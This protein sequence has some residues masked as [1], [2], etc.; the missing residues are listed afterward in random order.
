MPKRSVKDKPDPPKKSK[1]SVRSLKLPNLKVYQ[2]IIVL[3]VLGI[4]VPLITVS[5]ILYSLNQTALKR[6]LG[7]FTEHT[8]EGIYKD[9]L[10]EINWQ[11]EQS[12]QSVS[13]LQ[14]L[15]QVSPGLSSEKL[16]EILSK[17]QDNLDALALYDT[18]G[19]RLAIHYPRTKN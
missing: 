6:E 12:R 17:T 8:A 1:A 10:T 19:K 18:T 13:M 3:F 16:L 4:L 2:Q 14:T 11:A 5:I 9:L 7:K 15:H